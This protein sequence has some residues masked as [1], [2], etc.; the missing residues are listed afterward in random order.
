MRDPSLVVPTIAAALGV[1]DEGAAT[2]A[3]TLA[4]TIGD[5]RVLLVLDNLEQV[6]EA[7]PD[8]T[9]LLSRCPRLA[10]LAT[11]RAPL[12]VRGE[13][14]APVA[15][16]PCRRTWPRCRFPSI[17]ATPAVALFAARAAESSPGFALTAGN[18]AVVAAICARLDGLPLAIELAAARVKML[19]PDALLA[20][21]ERVLPTLT[22]GPRDLPDRQRT[23]RGA[24]A[25]SHDLLPEA[26]RALF[27][28]LAVFAGGFTIAAAE[29]V[30]GDEVCGVSDGVGAPSASQSAPPPSS[31]ASRR[32]SIRACCGRAR[33]RPTNRGTSCSER[34]ASS[35]WSNWRSTARSAADPGPPRRVLSGVRGSGRSRDVRTGGDVWL[36]RCDAERANLRAA[37]EWSAGEEPTRCWRCGS[38]PRCCDIGARGDLGEG[39]RWLER[40]LALGGQVPLVVRAK[41]LTAIGAILIVRREYGRAEE[42]LEESIRL[43]DEAGDPT[44]TA[45]AQTR[46]GYLAWG[47]GQIER[48]NVLLEDAVV[49][50]N[51]AGVTETAAFASFTLGLVAR[52][53]G[54]LDRAVAIF[55]EALRFSSEAG[56]RTGM[57]VSLGSLGWTTF[58]RGDIDEAEVF[59][60]EALALRFE[61]RDRSG[62]A[63]QLID[64]SI[65][66]A[67][68]GNRARAV[69]LYAAADALRE[70]R[71]TGV[72]AYDR[73][74]DEHLLRTLRE[75]LGEAGF[76][77][78]WLIGRGL[79]FE[80]AVAAGLEAGEV[81]G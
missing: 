22:G 79:R 30:V 53:A 42:L 18:A 39:A 52:Q 75:R 57:A 72:P 69:R 33:A 3:E 10:V 68:R 56:F 19:P 40:S 29:Q 28:R 25:W 80:D 34:C 12:A 49:G 23:L 77:A 70:S 26:E 62:T 67:E 64:L 73:E 27:R 2:P 51:A 46:L 47:M 65:Y 60:R 48:A 11:S 4:T 38:R 5:R 44:G 74:R 71:G 7:A 24:I 35:G 63:E 37:I 61:L 76:A 36:D 20:R 9:A 13:Q 16:S 58:M 45:L 8:I 78:E 59:S 54:E 14:I 41:A 50:L 43:S 55:R 15:R 81:A 66:A 17:A 21:L 31:R 6:L 32:C 1:R